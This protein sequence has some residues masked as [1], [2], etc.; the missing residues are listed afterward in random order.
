MSYIRVYVCYSW[1]LLA[2]LENPTMD[3][4]NGGDWLHAVDAPGS[5]APGLVEILASSVSTHAG[6]WWKN[7]L[8]LHVD[9]QAVL[10]QYM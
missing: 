7:V 5:R 4:S 8:W 6:K 1:L 3:I 2:F 9:M 10:E